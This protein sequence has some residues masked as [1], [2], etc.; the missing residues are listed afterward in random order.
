MTL[1]HG[2]LGEGL[3]ADEAGLRPSGDLL[4]SVAR[5]RRRDRDQIDR[6]HPSRLDRSID[7]FILTPA[8]P[9]PDRR[10]FMRL[11][12]GWPPTMAVMVAGGGNAD[13]PARCRPMVRRRRLLTCVGQGLSVVLLGQ[14]L[15][16]RECLP[17]RWLT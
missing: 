6:L 4:G 15:R 13:T 7:S 8:V 1:R 11:S 9:N 14:G 2:Y 3:A 17:H 12:T 16:L 10:D 5:R